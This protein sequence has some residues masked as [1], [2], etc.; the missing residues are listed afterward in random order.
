M[1]QVLLTSLH[2]R[3]VGITNGRKLNRQGEWS[4]VVCIQNKSHKNLLTARN[5]FRGSHIIAHEK[6][7]NENVKVHSNMSKHEYLYCL[8]HFIQNSAQ[9]FL[10]VIFLS[11]LE[12]ERSSKVKQP[13]REREQ[14]YKC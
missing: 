11:L 2:G 5:S 7:D 9:T 6:Y 1:S 13:K 4:P 3:H 10:H 8:I 14:V 12:V